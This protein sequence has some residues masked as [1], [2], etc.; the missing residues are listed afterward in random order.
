M[1]VD[2]RK[3][4]FIIG[5]GRSG[6][7]WLG[8]ILKS[9][10]NIKITIEKKPM[11]KW[12]T[13]IA[14]NKK[15]EK[16]L[17]YLLLIYYKYYLHKFKNYIYADKSHP[18]IWI[19]DKLSNNFP[20]AVFLGIE[21]NPYSVVTSMLKHE[22]VSAWHHKWKEFPIPNRFLGIDN[23]LRKEYENLPLESKCSLRW[24]AHQK[25][26]NYLQEQ[27]QNKILVLNYED[28]ILDINNQLKKIQD[29]LSLEELFPLPE[30]YKNS[31]NKWKSYLNDQQIEN[32]YNI[33]NVTPY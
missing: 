11:F 3:L 2:K 16:N 17:Y 4:T 20:N 13:K 7:H 19:A 31:L 8:Y 27:L 1:I 23:K 18:N 32:I 24:L 25:Q 10:P 29:F 12:S 26:M 22:G 14:L 6:T 30:I 5:T 28:M 21:R 15:Y 9:H 33:T